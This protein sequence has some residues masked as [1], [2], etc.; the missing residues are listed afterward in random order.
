MD[1]LRLALER[2]AT[3]EA[4]VGV[5][6]RAARDASAR[7]AAAGTSSAASRYHNSFL[8]ADPAR[9]LRARDGGPALGGRARDGRAHDLERPHARA[10]RARGE[11]PPAHLRRGGAA[12]PRLHAG[13]RLAAP[14]PC[15]HAWRC[16]ATTAAS[17][18]RYSLA[19]RRARR[20]VRA[21]RRP[22]RE[23]ADDRVVGERA[24]AGRRAAL[25]HRHG[26]AL[27]EPVQAGGGGRAARARP[28]A[29][30]SRRRQEPL[31]AAR[32]PAPRARCATPARWLP[33][34]SR[35]SAT[36]S[37]RAGSRRPPRSADAFAEADAL[38]EA[39][40]KRAAEPGPR[41]AG[42]GGRGAT[43]PEREPA[44]PALA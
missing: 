23:H 41:T 21:R 13:A 34:L 22:R 8:V 28:G 3:A 42:P 29:E 6:T 32:A 30:R 4:A 36:R 25:G 38:L 7:A 9:R 5:I 11:R 27:H 10:A 18:A 40:T 16:C 17:R 43:G 1:L 15:R 19:Q 12:A 35:T 31:V 39:W 37:R 20:A 2:A 26:G 14:R 33:A 44:R 24:D